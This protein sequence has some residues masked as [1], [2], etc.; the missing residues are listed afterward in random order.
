[1]ICRLVFRSKRGENLRIKEN[2]DEHILNLRK[3][4]LSLPEKPGVYIMKNAKNNIIYIGKAKILK[5]R[6]SQYFGSD[7]NHTEKVKQMVSQV[8]DF[9]YIICDSEFEALI[10]E[11]SLIKQ[12]MPKYNVLLKDDKGYHYIKITNGKFRTIKSA[13]QKDD[14]NAEYIGPYSSGW[15]VKKTVEETCKIFKLPQCGKEFYS[16]REQSRPCLNFYIGACSAPC[17]GKISLKEYNSLVNEALGFIKGGNKISVKQLEKE[18]STASENLDFE[19]AAKLRDRIKAIKS[20]GEKQKVI[21]CTY[22]SQDVFAFASSS[23]KASVEVFIFRNSRL[24]DRKQFYLDLNEDMFSFR[25]TFIKQYYLS[26]EIPPRIAVDETF[27]DMQLI[28]EMLSSRLQKKVEIIVP[29]IG[30]QK[31]LMEMCKNNA[32]EYIAEMEGKGRH[33]ASALEELAELLDLGKPP[34]YIESYD[35]SHTMGHENVAGMVVFKNG[36]PL[37]SAYKKFKIKSFE[38]QDDCRSMAEVIE[39]RF[40]EYLNATDK[41]KGFGKL[42]DLILLDGGITQLNAVNAVLNRLKIN[43]KVFGMVKDSKH[44]TNAIATNGGIIAIKSNRSAY[45][46]VSTIQEEVHRFAISFHRKKAANTMLTTELTQI[47]GVGKATAQK[48]LKHFKTINAIKNASIDK[49]SDI[50][51]MNKK[52]AKN[53]YLYFNTTE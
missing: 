1:M 20:I 36:Q 14:E 44:K 32:I 24:C 12:N 10:L 7:Y 51:G 4:S 28:S 9:E 47:P 8:N 37:K 50:S 33:T 5:N 17:A 19:L 49:L 39:R 6:V 26:S 11:C 42:P 45:T 13:L 35:I 21:S 3:K 38:G 34:E 29:K 25:A 52:T 46:L 18:M 30:E 48:L 23:K 43:I 40:T 41:D 27:E 16:S 53:I 15:V 22:D 31:S 2:R